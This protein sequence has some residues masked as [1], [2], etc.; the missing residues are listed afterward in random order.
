M[1]N[2]STEEHS[3]DKLQVNGDIS[4]RNSNMKTSF[5]SKCEPI[6]IPSYSVAYSHQFNTV[7][8]RNVDSHQHQL[9]EK[10]YQINYEHNDS[11]YRG[12]SKAHPTYDYPPITQPNQLSYCKNVTRAHNPCQRR[13]YHYESFDAENSHIHTADRVQHFPNYRNYKNSTPSLTS[14]KRSVGVQTSITF[15]DHKSNIE[16]QDEK[17][18]HSISYE[19]SIGSEGKS[20]INQNVSY[21]SSFGSVETLLFG[22]QEKSKNSFRI[23]TFSDD[24]DFNSIDDLK[25]DPSFSDMKTQSSQN[26]FPC[27]G[28]F[29]LPVSSSQEHSPIKDSIHKMKSDTTKKRAR[30]A[31]SVRECTNRVV[32]GGLCIKHGAKRKKC[33][34]PGCSKNVKKAGRC[35][36]H[37]PPRKRCDVEGCKNASV[38]GGKCISHGALKKSTLRV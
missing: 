36:T 11:R 2:N 34:Y 28:Y 32:Q 23:P 27:Q 30:R 5:I 20:T 38:K 37:G 19:K 18:I 26:Q 1:Q 7:P 22:D 9:H 15:K 10:Y 14:S 16:K 4:T 25:M 33:T 31:C 17:L 35:S 21:C 29:C 13:N 24:F 6:Y 3:N 8:S 12:H